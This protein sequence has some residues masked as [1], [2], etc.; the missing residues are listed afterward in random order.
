MAGEAAFFVF[1]GADWLQTRWIATHPITVTRTADVT[2]ITTL[3]EYNP[4]IGPHPTVGRVNALFAV[5]TLAQV[6][7]AQA[8]PH[9]WRA[10]WIAAGVALELSM[11]A[12][13]AAIGIRVPL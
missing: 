7:I 9:A 2:T 1:Q 6:L 5:T 12:H 4:L 13:N 8:L 11:V 10:P 3:G